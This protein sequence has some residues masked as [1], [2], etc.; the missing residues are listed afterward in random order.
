MNNAALERYARDADGRIIIDIATARIDNLFQQFDH[1]A[2]FAKKDLDDD[3][4]KYLIECAREVGNQPFVVRIHVQ[5]LPDEPIQQQT[6]RSIR[7]YFLYRAASGQRGLRVSL[8][9]SGIIFV[10]GLL[11]LALSLTAH[12]YAI[13]MQPLWP[14]LLAEGLTVAAWVALWQALATLLT[15]L[16]SGL[17]E[18]RR[19]QRIAAAPVEFSRRAES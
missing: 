8:R 5:A 9:V 2:P 11:L 19:Y 14:R 4:A 10:A 15:R 18:I 6:R 16:P 17:R 13:A 7:S 1:I 12:Q 3:L